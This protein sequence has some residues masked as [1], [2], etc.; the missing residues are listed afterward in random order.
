MDGWKN[1]S[2]S[3]LIKFEDEGVTHSVTFRLSELF[4]LVDIFKI[5][6]SFFGKTI[7]W[8]QTSMLLCL[9]LRLQRTQTLLC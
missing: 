3:N 4:W 1:V 9:L 7:M 6:F 5:T 2:V 8:E